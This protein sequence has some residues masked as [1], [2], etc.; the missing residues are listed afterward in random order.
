MVYVFV[1][2]HICDDGSPM[3]QTFFGGWAEHIFSYDLQGEHDD[4]LHWLHLFQTHKALKD[5]FHYKG[6]CD[7]IDVYIYI[8][9]RI[10]IYIYIDDTCLF[11]CLFIY[12][13]IFLPNLESWLRKPITSLGI[14]A[15]QAFVVDGDF[16]KIRP[17]WPCWALWNVPTNLGSQTLSSICWCLPS[18]KLT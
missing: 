16:E 11:V 18:S 4:G 3:T 13:P 5:Q 7:S 15:A 9:S 2:D 12:L 1:V 14:T 6:W 17:C 10:N 8:Q